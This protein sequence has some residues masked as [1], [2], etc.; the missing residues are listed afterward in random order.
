MYAE[1]T[2]VWIDAPLPAEAFGVPLRAR[3]AQAIEWPQGEDG[4]IVLTLTDV[5][6]Q[7][8]ALVLTGSDTV[9]LDIAWD[10]R[11]GPLQTI[12]GT[13]GADPGSYVFTL[14]PQT[15]SGYSGP[16]V[17]SVRAFMSGKLQ[18]VVPVGYFTVSPGAYP[19]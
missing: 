8:I 12:A 16:L 4:T 1:L 11:S 2:G 5:L 14:T 18:Q 17:F 13:Q 19:S 7:P 9:N 10:L 15:T 6:G 3:V